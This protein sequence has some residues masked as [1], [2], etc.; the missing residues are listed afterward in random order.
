MH[1]LCW[2]LCYCVALCGLY[3]HM[4]ICLCLCMFI[5]SYMECRDGCWVG[6]I[7]NLIFDSVIFSEVGAHWL[8]KLGK[9][10]QIDC[11]LVFPDRELHACSPMYIFLMWLMEIWIQILI[12]VPQALSPIRYQFL[13]TIMAPVNHRT[14]HSTEMCLSNFSHNIC[15]Q[16][17]NDFY[18]LWSTVK[19]HTFCNSI[20]SP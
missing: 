12:L 20:Y 19:I 3:M 5:H 1:R 4:C 18:L 15:P 10:P 17:I 6:I 16:Y 7:I 2:N 13:Q 8:A 14:N 11:W 9:S